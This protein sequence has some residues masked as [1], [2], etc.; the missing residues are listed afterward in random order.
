MYYNVLFK[1]PALLNSSKKLV[2]CLKFV[3]RNSEVRDGR[4]AAVSRLL[5]ITRYT[6]RLSKKILHLI[7]MF[8]EEHRCR[9]ERNCHLICLKIYKVRESSHFSPSSP[10]TIQSVFNFVSITLLFHSFCS[11]AT[12]YQFLF[13]INP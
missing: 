9:F 3:N 10:K 7:Q 11:L 8:C 4:K 12:L 6:Y 1:G 13:P 5:F 2:S